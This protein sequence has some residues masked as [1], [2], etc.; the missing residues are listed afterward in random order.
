MIFVSFKPILDLAAFNSSVC[1]LST[2]ACDCLN[3]SIDASTCT[4]TFPLTTSPILALTLSILLDNALLLVATVCSN[5]WIFASEESTLDDIL[6]ILE[7]SASSPAIRDFVSS[8]TEFSTFPI[9]EVRFLLMVACASFSE[10][11]VFRSS[12]IPAVNSFLKVEA[13]VVLAKLSALSP[14]ILARLSSSIPVNALS[15]FAVTVSIFEA[16]CLA[17]S[18]TV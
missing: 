12:D 1:A 10:T 11:L 3:S 5:V 4:V 16:F 13:K 8:V 9:F 2:S 6:V 7:P 18:E 17:F 15:D 14:A